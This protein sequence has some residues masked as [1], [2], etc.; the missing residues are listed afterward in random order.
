[1]GVQARRAFPVYVLLPTRKQQAD[2]GIGSCRIRLV[3]SDNNMALATCCGPTCQ[4][5]TGEAASLIRSAPW[6]RSGM[7]SCWLPP[8]SV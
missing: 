6:C 8:S 1:V 5:D 3:L 4:L 2:S 7:F